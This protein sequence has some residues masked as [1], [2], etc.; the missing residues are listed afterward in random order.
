MQLLPPVNLER[1]LVCR[2]GDT[3]L[4]SLSKEHLCAPKVVE[5]KVFQ[6]RQVG[7]LVYQVKVNLFSSGDLNTDVPFVEG[8][9]TSV[10]E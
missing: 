5:H 2:V 6:L 7:V 9:E 4:D 10:V 3:V 8:Q 1:T